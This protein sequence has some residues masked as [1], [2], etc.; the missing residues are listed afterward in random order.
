M[1]RCWNRRRIAPSWRSGVVRS[2]HGLSVTI[3]VPTFDTVIPWLT[4]S[5][6]VKLMTPRELGSLRTN[7]SNPF[8]M[9]WV[10]SSEAPCG[11]ATRAK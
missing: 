11:N 3:N 9:A 1:S 4:R 8:V 2:S 7:C 5:K 10:R 6:P